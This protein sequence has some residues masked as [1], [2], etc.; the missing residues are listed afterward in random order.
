M[1]KFSQG[2]KINNNE[3]FSF[4]PSCQDFLPS[5]QDSTPLLSSLKTIV[6]DKLENFLHNIKFKLKLL[7]FIR[8]LYQNSE[9]FLPP[10][11]PLRFTRCSW[12]HTATSLFAPPLGKS[13]LRAWLHKNHQNKQKYLRYRV[14]RETWQLVYRLSQETWQLVYRVSHETWQLV[15][16]STKYANTNL[17]NKKLPNKEKLKIKPHTVLN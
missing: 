15:N 7:V 10:A 12:D 9:H 2:V 14:S 11:R 8:F 13:W 3:K 17:T 16:K 1:I 6:V 4:T 5:C